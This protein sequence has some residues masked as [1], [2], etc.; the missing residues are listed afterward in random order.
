VNR[1]NRRPV[2]R[3]RQS[4]AVA[5]AEPRTVDTKP[6]AVAATPRPDPVPPETRAALQAGRLEQTCPDCGRHEA[7]GHHCS[8]CTRRMGPE[9]WSRGTATEAQ[10]AARRA[11][12][13][14]QRERGA[15]NTKSAKS[16]ALAATPPS[17]PNDLAP[18]W[19]AGKT[20]DGSVRSGAPH[21]SESDEGGSSAS[22]AGS[23]L[24]RSRSLDAG[25]PQLPLGLT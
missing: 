23:F 19:T 12:G 1:R 4:E 17:E 13:Q 5:L 7:A 18:D 22:P 10:L 15:S 24:S 25:A 11:S 16:D 9:D 21:M 14:R 8:G 20:R 2:Q 3:R 6:V